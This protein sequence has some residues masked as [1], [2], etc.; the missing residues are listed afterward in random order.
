MERSEIRY[1][2][3]LLRCLCMWDLSLSAFITQVADRYWCNGPDV[4]LW[5]SW[6]WYLQGSLVWKSRLF[7]LLGFLS[8]ESTPRGKNSSVVLQSLAVHAALADSCFMCWCCKYVMSKPPPGSYRSALVYCRNKNFFPTTI[9]ML[10]W[11]S[12]V[13]SLW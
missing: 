11:R 1:Y 2:L 9:F 3:T 12:K 8:V 5:Q 4:I 10:L 7:A 13:S 6:V